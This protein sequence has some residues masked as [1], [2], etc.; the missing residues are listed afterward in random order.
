VE[1]YATVGL[2]AFAGDL[3]TEN[4]YRAERRMLGEDVPGRGYY[5]NKG[6]GGQRGT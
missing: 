2:G 5:T 6:A 1:E 3:F 4:R